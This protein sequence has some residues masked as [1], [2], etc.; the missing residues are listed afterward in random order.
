V[1]HPNNCIFLNQKQKIMTNLTFKIETVFYP[2]GWVAIAVCNLN[3]LISERYEDED[4][5]LADVK[6]Q[7]DSFI[8]ETI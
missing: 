2:T 7:I 1:Q 5:A 6:N 4:D 8:Y 3:L